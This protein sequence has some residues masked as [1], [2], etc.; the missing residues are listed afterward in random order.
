MQQDI[1]SILENCID[2]GTR[3]LMADIMTAILE[4]S[5]LRKEVKQLDETL[6]RKRFNI[7][8]SEHGHIP[9]ELRVDL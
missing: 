3:P 2:T 9:T 1:V 4:I 5:R 6:S 8:T 7:S